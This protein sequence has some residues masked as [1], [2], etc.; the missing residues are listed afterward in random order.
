MIGISDHLFMQTALLLARRGLGN[1]SP[2]PAVG[3]VLVNGDRVV[4]VGWTQPGGR[5]HAETEALKHAGAEARGSTAYVTLEPCSHHGK[6]P[7]CADALILAGVSRV[8]VACTDPN[9]KVNGAG[10]TR[11]QQAGIAVYTGVCEQEA[12]ELNRGFFKRIQENGPEITVKIATTQ[13]GSFTLPNQKWITSEA[14]RRYVHLMRAEQ[15]AIVTGIGTVLADDPQL[16]C[17]LPG[18]EKESPKA[19]VLDSH[20]RIPET[21]KLVRE[22]TVIFTLMESLKQEEKVRRLKAKGMEIIALHEMEGKPWL[23]AVAHA[24]ASRDHNRLMVEAGPTLSRAFLSSGLVDSLYWFK[25]PLT[26]GRSDFIYNPLPFLN[27]LAIAEDRL[28]IYQTGA[29]NKQ[30]TTSD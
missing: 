13:D 3:C 14:S 24:V 18:L 28:D 20:L 12:L 17:R 9:P 11:M 21:A 10:I 15:D 19:F 1:T 23:L 27:R 6:T 8:V 16:T 7:P 26:A 2:N 4:G 25:S 30:P 29:N 5:P 22:G